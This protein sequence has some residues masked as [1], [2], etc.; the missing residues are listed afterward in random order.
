M[1]NL[2]FNPG[3]QWRMRGGHVATIYPFVT[4]RNFITAYYLDRMSVFQPDGRYW[5]HEEESE[6]DLIEPVA[7]GE[8]S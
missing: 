5:F 6:F 8:Q 2:Q 1:A 3:D 4:D 7:A